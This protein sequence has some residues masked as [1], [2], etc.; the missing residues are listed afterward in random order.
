MVQAKKRKRKANTGL[1]SGRVMVLTRPFSD[2]HP[3]WPRAVLGW[4]PVWAT[5]DYAYRAVNG[6]VEGREPKFAVQPRY[7]AAVKR[8]WSRAHRGYRW[9][10]Q[11]APVSA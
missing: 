5:I 11:I 6:W 2:Q 8:A 7:V 10:F 1:K 9:R 3:W 4:P